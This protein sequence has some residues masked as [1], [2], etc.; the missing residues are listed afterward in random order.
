VAM[1]LFTLA[2]APFAC[3]AAIRLVRE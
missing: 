2:A 1:T 3:A